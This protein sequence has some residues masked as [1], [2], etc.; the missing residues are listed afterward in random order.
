M[1]EHPGQLPGAGGRAVLWVGPSFVGRGAGKDSEGPGGF[2][3]A[4]PLMD[5]WGHRFRL[6]SQLLI[7]ASKLKLK[8]RLLNP[9]ENLLNQTSRHLVFFHHYC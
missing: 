2:S 1:A 4:C 3:A 8:Y 9:T 5:W 6:R 7:F